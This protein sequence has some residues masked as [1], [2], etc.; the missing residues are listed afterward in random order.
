MTF[1]GKRESEQK[2][3]GKLC[4]F[5][6]ISSFFAAKK[7]KPLDSSQRIRDKEMALIQNEKFDVNSNGQCQM[8]TSLVLE[9]RISWYSLTRVYAREIAISLDIGGLEKVRRLVT[10]VCY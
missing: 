1:N 3:Y 10:A 7:V 6:Y 9:Y 5:S 4:V 8:N 2:Y